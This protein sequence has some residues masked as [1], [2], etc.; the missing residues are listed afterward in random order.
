MSATT[1]EALGRV[2]TDSVLLQAILSAMQSCMDMCGVNAPCVAV[3]TIPTR[4]PGNITGMIGLHGQASGFVTVNLAERAAMAAVGGLL[5]EKFDRLGPQ[6]VDGAG[7][8]TNIIAGGIK[9]GLA[10]TP[11]A[12]THVTVPSVIIGRN[13]QI[14][15][16]RGLEYVCVTFECEDEDVLILDD[17][18]IQVSLSLIRL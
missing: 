11:W 5:Q 2:R 16:A 4:E 15:Y 8:I 3:S 6:V 14:A 1:A 18:L 10:G 12:F 13:Y 9:R 17:R 7:E